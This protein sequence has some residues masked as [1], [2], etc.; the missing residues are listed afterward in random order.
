MMNTCLNCIKHCPGCD[1]FMSKEGIGYRSFN[2][3]SCSVELC[4]NCIHYEDKI[5]FC[6]SEKCSKLCYQCFTQVPNLL[7]FNCDYCNNYMCKYHNCRFHC[8]KCDDKICE[9]CYKQ[10][11]CS[12]M[13]EEKIKLYCLPKI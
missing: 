1:M 9:E 2:C 3:N 4:E 5:F 10:Y 13:S 6:S 11:G 12:C 8:K 7:Q